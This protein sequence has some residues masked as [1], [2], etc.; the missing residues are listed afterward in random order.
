MN[1][2]DVDTRT[3]EMRIIQGWYQ[4]VSDQLMEIEKLLVEI[5]SDI[6]GKDV[7]DNGE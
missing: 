6:F 5:H 2:P 3:Q 4:K 1:K 7:E